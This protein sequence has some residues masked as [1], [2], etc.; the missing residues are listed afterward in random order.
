MTLTLGTGQDGAE[1]HRHDELVGR[2]LVLHPVRE[3]GLRLGDGHRRATPATAP[4]SPSSTSSTV[5]VSNCGGGGGGGGGGSGGVR[6]RRVRRRLQRAT[7]G[8]RRPGLR[9]TSGQPVRRRQTMRLTERGPSGVPLCFRASGLGDHERRSRPPED[10]RRHRGARH[11]GV[12]SR[13]VDSRSGPS[14]VASSPAR[15]GHGP[16][17][18]PARPAAAARPATAPPRPRG[19]RRRRWPGRPS[20]QPCPQRVGALAHGDQGEPEHGDPVDGA[21]RPS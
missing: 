16:L 15:P 6:W 1:L 13:C 2:G 4:T 9:L 10:E 14:A 19:R 17:R 5:K 18:R 20:T 7:A 11:D 8:R 12:A 21:A 3:P